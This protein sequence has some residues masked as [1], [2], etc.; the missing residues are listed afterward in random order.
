MYKLPHWMPPGYERF[1]NHHVG[2][3][4]P[5]VAMPY[6][7]YMPLSAPVRQPTHQADL[8]NDDNNKNKPCSIR[9]LSLDGEGAM[10]G[11]ESRTDK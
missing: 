5:C 8:N 3:I 4:V 11:D 2:V 6:N 9:A 7:P 1:A 10:V